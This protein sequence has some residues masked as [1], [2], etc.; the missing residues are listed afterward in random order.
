MK[1]L[2]LIA[3]LLSFAPPVSAE[4]DHPHK[5]K[6]P[7]L[8][9]KLPKTER[10]VLKNGM[11]LHLLENHELPLVDVTAMVRIGS[12]YE[13]AQKAGLAALTGSVWR[14][15]GIVGMSSAELD[16]KL[17]FKGAFL[18]TSI[19]REAGSISFSAL[20][21]DVD[22]VLRLFAELIKKP[23]FD[24]KR[25]EVAKERM[26]EGIKRQNDD[27]ST[28]A[29]REFK[30]LLL[31]NHPMGSIPTLETVARISK[32][33]CANFY[34]N[35][36]GPE[37][38]IVGVSG[39]FDSAD[40]MEKFE[41]LFAGFQPA[42]KKLPEIPPL[43]EKVNAGIYVADKKLQ[44]TVFRSG[45]FG[46][47]RRNPDYYSARVMN[48]ILGGGGFSSRLL[49]EIRSTRGLAYSVWSYFYGGENSR[50]GF[51]TGGE[52]KSA[53]SYEFI[54]ATR[55]IM[56]RMIERG[57]TEKELTL[58]KESITNSF[59]FGFDKDAKI[60]SKYLWL[61]YYNLPEDY[62]ETFIGGIRN[63]TRRDVK[64]SAAKYLHP[65]EMIILA[66]GDAS[67]ISEDMARMGPVTIIKL[68][69]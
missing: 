7:P 62:L 11:I 15:G 56:R 26:V 54:Q 9:F 4:V 34:K 19:G 3:V 1:R 8:E 39:D 60:V 46:I 69:E 51:M 30:R 35:H 36:V 55:D 37:S 2:V 40:I 48:F 13:P 42:M 63:V 28:I 31:P 49:K 52:T 10:V 43:P 64:A 61:D 38:F 17:E 53:S 57:V 5:L 41:K 66:V 47:S 16:E 6:Y 27:P 22:E 12:V 33:D 65:D 59:V 67:V 50:G 58:A 25:F 45:H 24:Q 32:Q 29:S 14:S 18:E 23:A 44:Q 21:K 20:T 68:P